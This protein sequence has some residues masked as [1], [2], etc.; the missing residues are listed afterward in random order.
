MHLGSHGVHHSHFV[1]PKYFLQKN[2]AE[3]REIT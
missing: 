3:Y 2:A 1:S